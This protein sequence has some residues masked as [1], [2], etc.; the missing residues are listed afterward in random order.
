MAYGIPQCERIVIRCSGCYNGYLYRYTFICIHRMS[1][2]IRIHRGMG[3]GS[4]ITTINS[5]L[6]ERIVIRYNVIMSYNYPDKPYVLVLFIRIRYTI[7]A[8]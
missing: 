2:G 8:L 6:K 7:I 5:R 4:I 1:Y 3:F